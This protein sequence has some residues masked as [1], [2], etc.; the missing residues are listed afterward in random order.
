MKIYYEV[1]YSSLENIFQVAALISRDTF[2]MMYQIYH[3]DNTPI[4]YKFRLRICGWNSYWFFQYFFLNLRNNR[5]ILLLDFFT[6]S[7][8]YLYYLDVGMDVPFGW[9]WSGKIEKWPLSVNISL[10]R[11]CQLGN[12]YQIFISPQSITWA[13]PLEKIKS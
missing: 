5:Y 4:Y 3:M 13:C 10:D 8:I 7:A 1:M 11:W 6:R 9:G 2:F 12:T